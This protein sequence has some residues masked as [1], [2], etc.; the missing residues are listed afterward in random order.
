MDNYEQHVRVGPSA[1]GQGVFS[2]TPLEIH[3]ILGPIRG[4][5]IVDVAYGSDYCMQ[6]GECS[7][8][9]PVPPFRYLNHSCHPNCSLVGCEVKSADGAVAFELGL[10]VEADIA[11]GEELTIDYGWPAS[12]ALPCH[13][14]SADCRKWIVAADEVDKIAPKTSQD[15]V[16]YRSS[17]KQNRQQAAGSTMLAGHYLYG[18][19]FKTA[20]HGVKKEPV[21]PQGKQAAKRRF[22]LESVLYGFQ[23][24]T[25]RHEVKKEP[26][27]PQGK[28]VAKR[29]FEL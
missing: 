7:S 12:N 21:F 11:P 14:G 19:Q 24:K 9:E 1:N 25:A 23:F 4:T 3:D 20:R 29:R 17:D 26:V 2:I 5:V 28:Q 10:Q 22:E 16:S 13:C 8:L 27:F 6:I 18:F 15:W